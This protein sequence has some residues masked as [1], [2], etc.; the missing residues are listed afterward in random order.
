M[1]SQDARMRELLTRAETI[2]VVG[3]SDKPERDSHQIAAY[4]RSVGYRVVPVNP[5]V[6]DVFGE[7]SYPDLRTIPPEIRVDI[8]D[9][10]R[11][12][13]QVGPVVD[14][15]MARHIPT[16]WMQ[17]GVVNAEA[18]AKARAAGLTVFEDL[19]IMVQHKRL[20]IPPKR[21]PP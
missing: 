3:L 8:A 7:R 19:C 12:S 15:A 11:R 10:F 1:E 5:V 18:T 16:V 9:I 21:S 13:D 6:P 2:A 20:K 17:L 4:L 14:D